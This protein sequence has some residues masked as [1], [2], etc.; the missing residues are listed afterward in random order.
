MLAAS[1]SNMYN[2][3]LG[4]N[5]VGGVSPFTVT[6]MNDEGEVLSN[7]LSMEGV[8]SGDYEV[9][10]TDSSEEPQEFT[11][12]VT[13]VMLVKHILLMILRVMNHIMK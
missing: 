9:N 7:E 13:S 11:S 5:I 3:Q 10:V 8:A 1:S 12:D 6:W 4:V 2:G